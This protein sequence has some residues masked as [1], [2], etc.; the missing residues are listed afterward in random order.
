MSHVTTEVSLPGIE[1][2]RVAT[3]QVRCRRN[4]K[5][6]TISTRRYGLIYVSGLQFCINNYDNLVHFLHLCLLHPQMYQCIQALVVIPNTSPA[7]I[8]CLTHTLS[9]SR[10]ASMI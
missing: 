5:Y 7:F 8:E 3:R 1:C 2:R 9:A 4:D 6:Y 10:Y